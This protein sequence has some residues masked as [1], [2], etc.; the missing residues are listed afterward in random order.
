M[1]KD[2][3]NYVGN[4]STVDFSWKVFPLNNNDT[5]RSIHTYSWDHLIDSIKIIIGYPLAT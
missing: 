5:E 1:R 3:K 4:P 2:N